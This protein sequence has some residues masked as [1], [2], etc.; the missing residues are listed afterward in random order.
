MKNKSGFAIVLACIGLFLGG[1]ATKPQLP[2]ALESEAISTKAG[3][4][5]VAMTALPKVDT[6]FPGAGCLLCLA[7]ANIANSTLS[8]HTQTLTHEDLPKLKNQ[9]AD[10]LR[11]KGAEVV[12]IE[13][14]LIVADL[15]SSKG[16]APNLARQDFSS[17]QKKY[18]IDK[19][20]VINVA[21]IGVWRNYAA[22]IPNGDPKG[23]LKGAG[24]MVNLK[25]NVY[26]WYLPVDI[27]KS[28]DG[29][30]DEPPKFPGLTNAYFQALELA[31][32]AFLKPFSN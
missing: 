12:L 10:I 3:K 9:I 27:N 5:G 18:N 14:A 1:C 22:Y 8:T 30:W 29:T 13:E 20:V 26:E 4:I 31:K 7:A 19:L 15:P 16:E 25:N 17:I 6:Q 32:D 28:A 21:A 24:Y 2:V 23:T 11:K